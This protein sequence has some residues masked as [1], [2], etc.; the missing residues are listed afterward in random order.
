M[1]AAC[2]FGAGVQACGG[3]VDAAIG[4]FA[5]QHFDI[6]LLQG[7]A[8]GTAV[9]AAAGAFCGLTLAFLVAPYGHTSD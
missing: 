1:D 5:S 6:T 2:R 4:A 3:N 9:G 7:I 8:S